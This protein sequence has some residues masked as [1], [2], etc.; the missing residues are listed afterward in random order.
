VIVGLLRLTLRM[1]VSSSIHF[2]A[3]DIISFFLWLIF[4]GIHI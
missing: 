4:H 1:M 2:L 3:N